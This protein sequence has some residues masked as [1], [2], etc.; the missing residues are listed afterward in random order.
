MQ[1]QA[2]ASGCISQQTVAFALCAAC[3]SHMHQWVSSWAWMLTS[4][5]SSILVCVFAAVCLQL[6][7]D[8]EGIAVTSVMG[9]VKNP[10][11]PHWRQANSIPSTSAAALT[12][13]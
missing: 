5:T 3:N 9:F 13:Q 6:A 2:V 1:R 8:S 11:S 10:V 12:E 4:I 7:F